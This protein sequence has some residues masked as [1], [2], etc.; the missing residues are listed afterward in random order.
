MAD[1]LPDVEGLGGRLHE[2]RPVYLTN[3][4]AA[5]LNALWDGRAHLVST[6]VVGVDAGSELFVILSN[7]ADSDRRLVLYNRIFGNDRAPS[8]AHLAYRAFVNPTA[9]L[10]N[11]PAS[12]NAVIGGPQGRGRFTYQVDTPGAVV[13]G[14]IEATGEQLPNG[15]P[16]SRK[17]DV[18][19]DPGVRVGFAIRGAD[20][21]PIASAANVSIILEWYEVPV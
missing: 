7:P 11:A 18:V 5:A 16:Y 4:P 6:P 14:G 17:V 21:G 3:G 13:M 12:P 8:A 20:G 2:A 15:I 10:A 19:V 1:D 9:T